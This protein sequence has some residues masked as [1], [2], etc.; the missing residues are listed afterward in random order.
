MI[1]DNEN[2]MC[3]PPRE[4]KMS[5][6]IMLQGTMSN[7]G[8]S[9]LAAGLCRIFHQDGYRVA[10]F[11]SQNMAL[12]SFITSEGLEIGR[13]Q[14]V[15]AE[16]AGTAPRV[17]M[18][19]VL[20]KPTTDVGSQVIVGGK[21][22]ANMPAREYF[23]YKQ[24]LIPEI[25]AAY[26]RLEE[27]YDIIVIEGA[28][29]PAEINLKENDIVNMG[30]AK[31]VNAPVL[32][33]GDIDPGGVF[34]QLYGTW[35]LLE[36]E[37]QTR[38]KG[39]IINKFRGDESLLT[40]GVRMIEDKMQIPVVG[41]IPYMHLHID[42][43]DS[44]STVLVNGS[45]KIFDLAVI[46]LPRL[47]NYTDFGP[48]MD[49]D[50]VSV[51][52][53]SSQEELGSPDIIFLPGTKSTISDLHW[54]KRT[55]LAQKIQQTHQTGTP[56]FGICGGYQMMGQVILDPEGVE[57]G[58][59]ET[60]LGIL[61]TETIL[62]AQK[63]RTQVS[64]MIEKNADGFFSCLSRLPIRGYEIHMGRTEPVNKA[65]EK[66]FS[67]IRT[68]SGRK[69][70]ESPDTQDNAQSVHDTQPADRNSYR[71]DGNSA[72]NAAGTYVHGIFDAPGVA[73]AILNQIALRRG[74]QISFP[75][76]DNRSYMDSQYDLLA[77]TL[78]KHMDVASIYR[79]MGM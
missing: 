23:V 44:L 66:D 47:S 56:I 13:A 79:M 31:M 9:L 61:N 20:L 39:L 51:R 49:R 5:H 16:A 8:K 63:V 21:V 12:N 46:R 60:G 42:D 55:G 2:A 4:T 33:V 38:I 64:G 76:R 36:K 18:N 68:E 53:V 32:L 78:R 73:E 57:G 74:L 27:D 15:Q 77:D 43:E 24:Q 22:R 72:L 71:P 59:E 29:S 52:F 50:N 11:K 54:L 19:P 40:P 67:Q 7:A 37:E 41:V 6:V 65:A 69:G 58:G 28:G 26:H 48:F 17:D 45:A 35:A 70:N 30:L 62:T 10:P 75:V 34:A 25:L 1:L 3:M 14:A